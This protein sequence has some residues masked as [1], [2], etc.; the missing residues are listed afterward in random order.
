MGKGSWC[1][2]CVL[3]LHEW[4]D[5]NGAH[6]CMCVASN[7]R[8]IDPLWVTFFMGAAQS[9][10]NWCCMCLTACVKQALDHGDA[11]FGGVLPT[12]DHT[13][14]IQSQSTYVCVM[15]LFS[16]KNNWG[17]IGDSFARVPWKATLVLEKEFWFHSVH[18]HLTTTSFS[19]TG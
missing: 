19:H 18:T 12:N 10:G 17:R 11:P 5:V 15:N 1:C 3:F 9:K 2:V 13:P 16:S 14:H 6:R 8:G 7:S 4:W